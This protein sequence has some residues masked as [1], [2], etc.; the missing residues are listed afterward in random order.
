MSRLI[1]TLTVVLPAIILL[2]FSLTISMQAEAGVAIDCEGTIQAWQ[3]DRSMS[4]F[5]SSHSCSCS[6]GSDKSPVCSES[7]STK[8]INNS[9]GSSNILKNTVKQTLVEGVV[10]GL[11]KPASSEERQ[12]QCQS[13]STNHLSGPAKDQSADSGGEA[14]TRCR[15]FSQSAE[16]APDLKG[17]IT[18]SKPNVI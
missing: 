14:C 2:V 13:G 4:G 12:R 11:L 18:V 5:M 3:N 1:K 7:G 6:N 16:T 15:L 8:G 17:D 10:G 9:K